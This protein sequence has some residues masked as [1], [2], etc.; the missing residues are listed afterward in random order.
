[1]CGALLGTSD[2]GT[3][4]CGGVDGLKPGQYATLFWDEA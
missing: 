1:V 2:L 4:A 3:H